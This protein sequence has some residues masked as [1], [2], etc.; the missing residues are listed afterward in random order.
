MDITIT[1]PIKYK[2]YPLRMGDNMFQIRQLIIGTFAILSVTIV[3]AGTCTLS[4]LPINPIAP[5]RTDIFI[6]ESKLIE[7]QFRNEKTEGNVEVFPESPFI[8]KNHKLNTTCFIDGG[9]WVRKSVFVSNNDSV[10]VTQEFSGSN[11]SLNFYD[12]RTCKKINEIDVSNS[13]WVIRESE[14]SI[15]RQDAMNKK[16]GERL[17]TY[18]LNESCNPVKSNKLIQRGN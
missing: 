7:V 11:D 17:S 2:Q 9:V 6:G 5:E 16:R 12:V 1:K 3:N 13:T 14:I 4:I 10:V 8:V 15:S 18:Q